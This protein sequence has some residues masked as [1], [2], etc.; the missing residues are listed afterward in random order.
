MQRVLNSAYSQYCQGLILE[1]VT[2]KCFSVTMLCNLTLKKSN[3]PKK[4]RGD[5][6]VFQSKGNETG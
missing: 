3:V 6:W 2:P 4:N 5:T 1:K